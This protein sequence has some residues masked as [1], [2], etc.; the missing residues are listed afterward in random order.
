MYE[1]NDVRSKSKKNSSSIP[2]KLCL[3]IL[4][5][6]LFNSNFM[7][8]FW[9]H[10]NGNHDNDGDGYIVLKNFLFIPC[11]MLILFIMSSAISFIFFLH[12]YIYFCVIHHRPSL[13]S[14]SCPRNIIHSLFLR[15]YHILIIFSC[16]LRQ[17]EIII[18]YMRIMR[19]DWYA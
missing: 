1:S 9:S 12:T 16:I 2:L 17:M 7:I 4:I 6:T 8:I 10:T 19:V 15:S 3:S 18:I 13:S 5:M 11:Q 14:N